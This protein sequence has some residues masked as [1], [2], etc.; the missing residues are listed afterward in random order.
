MRA[1]RQSA[2]DTASSSWFDAA[3]R[4]DDAARW[5][6]ERDERRQRERERE[7]EH[8]NRSDS[9]ER[10]TSFAKSRVSI[11][12]AVA[13]LAAQARNT[14]ALRERAGATC[15]RRATCRR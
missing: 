13:R 11:G 2:P 7:R 10:T 15:W 5:T 3:T 12:D 1:T 6:A 9:D 8:D 14:A 4:N